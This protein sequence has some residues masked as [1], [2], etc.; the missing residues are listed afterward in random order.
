[1][2]VDGVEDVGSVVR[3]NAIFAV[4]ED[5]PLVLEVDASDEPEDGEEVGGRDDDD[6]KFEDLVQ[7]EDQH[8]PLYRVDELL[9]LVPGGILQLLAVVGVD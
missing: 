6:H 5:S 2:L 7:V 1:M 8:V 3:V 9:V 4:P